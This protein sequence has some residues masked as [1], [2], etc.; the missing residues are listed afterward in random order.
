MFNYLKT[1]SG[2]VTTKI[3]ATLLIMTLTFANFIFLGSYIGKWSTSIAADEDVTEANNVFF[4]VYLD[5]AKIMKEQTVDINNKDLKLFVSVEVKNQ[6]SLENASITLKNTNF[7]LKADNKKTNI[8]L[9]TIQAGS[10]IEQAYEIVPKTNTEFNLDWLNMDSI[11]ALTGTYRS[12]AGAKELNIENEKNQR[13]VHINLDAPT[14]IGEEDNQNHKVELEQEF[15]TNEVLKVNGANKQ[16]I[17]EL[18]TS[19]IKDNSYPVKT[20]NIEIKAPKLGEKFP[21]S[22]KV[23]TYGTAATNGKY[24]EFGTKQDGKLGFY[25]YDET[26]HIIKITVN[27]TPD[28]NNII[29]WEKD[30]SDTFVVTYIYEE[31][32][33]TTNVLAEVKSKITMYTYVENSNENCAEETKTINTSLEKIQLDPMLNIGITPEVFKGNMKIGKDTEF[34]TLWIAGVSDV[35]LMDSILLAD[36]TEEAEDKFNSETE[37][38]PMTYY[39][40]TYI[41]AEEMKNLLGDSGEITITAGTSEI[42]VNAE[43]S[44]SE[45]QGLQE[46]YEV[47][48]S[49]DVDSIAIQTSKPVK[50]GTITIINDKIL[51]SDDVLKEALSEIKSLT[52]YTTLSFLDSAGEIEAI[53]SCGKIME[54]SDT[55]QKITV[56]TDK[57]E[58][59]T[60]QETEVNFTITLKEDDIKYNLFKEPVITIE[61]PSFVKTIGNI[62]KNTDIQLINAE[63]STLAIDEVSIDKSGETPKIVIKLTGESTSYGVNPQI[64]L[65]TI[66]GTDKLIP[67]IEGNVHVSAEAEALANETIRLTAKAENKLLTAVTVKV[68]EGETETAFKE[69]ITA[70][71]LQAGNEEKISVVATGT[72]INNT[73]AN[74]SD[75][76]V[77]GKI[78]KGMNA[79]L[80]GITGSENIYYTQDNEVSENSNWVST[81]PE[82]VTGYK[83]VFASINNAETKTFNLNLELPQ[84]LEINKSMNINYTVISGETRLNSPVLT[85]MTPQQTKLMLTVTPSA[86]ENGI[87]YEG[88]KITYTVKVKNTGNNTVTNVNVKNTVP[89]GTTLVSG[90]AS[91]WQIDSLEAGQEDTRTMELTVNNLANGENSKEIQVNTEV[92][93]TYLENK[94][95]NTIKHTVNKGIFSV[96]FNL[97]EN[98]NAV[99]LGNKIVYEIEVTNNS[100]EKLQN[101]LISNKLSEGLNLDYSYLN[102]INGQQI[103]YVYP[104]DNG[105]FENLSFEAGE[106]KFIQMD[107]ILEN[108]IENGVQNEIDIQLG[109]QKIA[110]SDIR[111]MERPANI[112]LEMTSSKEN[113]DVKTG[114]QIVYN[115]KVTNP[116]TKSI[117]LNMVAEVSDGLAIT[118]IKSAGEKIYSDEENVF[119]LKNYEL[120]NVTFEAESTVEFTMTAKVVLNENMELS[121]KAFCVSDMYLVN[122]NEIKNTLKK[123]VTP[124]PDPNPNPNPTAEYSLSG[125][126][127]LDENKDGVLD[128]AEKG[129]SKITVNIKDASTGDFLKDE[130][131]N[132]LKALTNSNGEYTL[133]N[134]KAGKY[135]LVFDCDVNSYGVTSGEDSIGVLTTENDKTFIKTDTIEITDSDIN[136]LNVGLVENPKFD[137]QLDKYVTK[138]TVKNVDG[139]TTY[140]YDKTQLAK[141]EIDAKKMAGSVVIVEYTIDVTNKGQIP[142]CANTIVDYASPEYTF[143]SEINTNWY[144]GSG[145]DI[146]CLEL[147]DEVIKPGETKSVKL[148][149]TKTMTNT[150]TGLISNTAEINEDFNEFALKDVNSTPANKEQKEN[151]MSSA[152]VIISVKTGGT[153]MYIGIF[154]I[155]MLILRWRNLFSK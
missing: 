112:A 69:N 45:K 50:E 12:D 6:G 120:D 38:V 123:T 18:V 5:E 74:L 59:S 72:V 125:K 87:V 84:G 75:V 52:T 136:N 82:N 146:Y 14:K 147:A 95:T 61:L 3:L 89:Q 94:L 139:T 109:N 47:V 42:K 10:K 115:I 104:N 135:I 151:D 83:I 1:E 100:N 51:K 76:T 54:I 88:Q 98:Y 65:K 132:E 105:E 55:M 150:N 99:E 44:K 66:L 149:L 21:E 33:Q 46:Y 80:K 15:I 116:D 28:E 24:L 23:A 17:Q 137:L 152:D 134:L 58:I 96:Q 2:K 143:S 70:K 43:T 34:R 63:G 32:V 110:F 126:V 22:I 8:S 103:E 128:S 140:N 131:G 27:N 25:E 11:I 56:E 37:V 138:V 101:V 133:K 90:S 68:G 20:T 144:Q 64:L 106:T 91:E 122:S 19:N 111:Q 92:T 4:N 129:L 41:N 39:K 148:V 60:T 67:T 48:Y 108:Y 57:K 102:N 119:G 121:A 62:N 153:G 78:E 107:V 117:T 26:N 97:N 124:N 127:W 118:S 13:K 85:V 155:S 30:A 114:D 29:S 7:E 142:G 113:K 49:G 77:I 145:N 81:A 71:T 141:I 154:I 86:Q 130:N 9:G 40:A 79:S 31:G 93:N 16:V 35:N 73:G 53:S 36:I